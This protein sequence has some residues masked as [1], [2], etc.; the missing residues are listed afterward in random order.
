MDICKWH[1]NRR[2]SDVNCAALR[3][4]STAWSLEGRSKE[5]DDLGPKGSF[6]RRQAATIAQLACAI[7][8]LLTM[9]FATLGNQVALLVRD[10]ASLA[11]SWQKSGIPTLLGCLHPFRAC[12]CVT[13]F[14][15]FRA[16]ARGRNKRSALRRIVFE[17]RGHGEGSDRDPAGYGFAQPALR[18]L[19]STRAAVCC[20]CA[21]GGA[22]S[23]FAT[24][25]GPPSAPSARGFRP[26]CA[27]RSGRA[28]RGSDRRGSTC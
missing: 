26:G 7:N 6:V 5:K 11:A 15:P 3:L 2:R 20:R 10:K 13:V 1:S 27:P 19:S 12:G 21:Q 18:E 17:R 14:A 24:P 8:L 9:A 4:R 23:R 28:C 25:R 16:T 22:R